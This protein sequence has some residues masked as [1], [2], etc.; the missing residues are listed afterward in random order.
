MTGATPVRVPGDT[1]RIFADWVVVITLDGGTKGPAELAYDEPPTISTT[2]ASRARIVT[3]FLATPFKIT[4]VEVDD[5]EDAGAGE[6]ERAWRLGEVMARC[7]ADM[8]TVGSRP[9]S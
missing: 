3:A 5:S 8:T 2:E 6:A 4:G 7:S 1:E 9:S